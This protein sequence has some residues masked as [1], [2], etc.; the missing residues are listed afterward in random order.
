MSP[1]EREALRTA[2]HL[3]NLDLM[4]AE[5]NFFV[6]RFGLVYAEGKAVII[7]DSKI[8]TRNAHLGSASNV[9]KW[10]QGSNGLKP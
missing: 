3:Y 10:Y 9:L 1:R 8:P 6:V 7:G 4:G 5:T 2:Y